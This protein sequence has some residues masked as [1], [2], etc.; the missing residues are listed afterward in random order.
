MAAEYIPTGA[1]VIQS[2]VKGSEDKGSERICAA[3]VP[4]ADGNITQDLA[5]NTFHSHS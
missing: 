1:C 4:R 5:Q 3:E 2:L